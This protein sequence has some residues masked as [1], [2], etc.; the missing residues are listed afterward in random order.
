MAEWVYS[1]KSATDSIE[2]AQFILN[3]EV[4]DR[5]QMKRKISYEG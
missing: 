2:R 4:N 3:I 1:R 5:F